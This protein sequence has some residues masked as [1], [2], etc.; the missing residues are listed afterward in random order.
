[1]TDKTRSDG[2]AGRP[3]RGLIVALSV[4]LYLILTIVM[5][6]RIRAA[7]DHH[8]FFALDDPYIHLALAKS[9][10]QGFYGIN[11]GDPASPSSSILWP[12]LLV[13]FAAKSWGPIAA[14]VLN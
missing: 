11:P 9:I 6:V 7:N 5:F 4:G 3:G 1:M 13:P 8:F 10:G 12:L 14:L 2:L